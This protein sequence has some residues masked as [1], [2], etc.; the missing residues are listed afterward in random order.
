[1][2]EKKE[3]E[4]IY[5]IKKYL[6][7]DAILPIYFLFGEDSFTINNVIKIIE[8]KIIPL[9]TADFDR[10]SITLTKDSSISQFIDLAYSFPFG[11]GK[12][13]ITVRNFEAINDK[14]LL[15]NYIKDPAEFTVLIIAQ[16][17]KSAPLNQ[18]PYKSLFA[19]NYIFEAREMRA[20]ELSEWMFKKAKVEKLNL[21][22]AAGQL[23]LEMVGESKAV[24]EMQLIKIA[25][26]SKPG[27][28]ITPEIIKNLAEITKEYTIFDLQNALGNGNKEKAI[29]Y[30][31]N[32]IDSDGNK[33]TLIIAMLTKYIT[34]LTQILGITNDAE[35]VKAIGG[36]YY[37][38]KKI[39]FLRNEKRLANAAKALLE[40]DIRLK[41][42]TIDNKT[43]LSI[44]IAQIL[45]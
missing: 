8:K 1:M 3:I 44:L 2:S 27:E 37:Y 9:V 18:E 21:S 17:S 38:A 11:N 28:E 45:K 4:S 15:L 19:K 29:E 32:L 36:S 24:L 25:T 14:K 16:Y 35:G 22:Q 43:N 39:T 10:E 5:N 26:Y 33:M 12:K 20:N 34:N 42:T 13:L 23:L 6:Q 41:T 40:A 7:D 30:A 31:F